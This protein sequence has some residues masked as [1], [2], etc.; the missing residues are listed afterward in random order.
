MLILGVAIIGL[1]ARHR[2]QGAAVHFSMRRLAASAA[3]AMTG[4]S[5]NA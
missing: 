1:A 5:R 4:G 3:S 2:S